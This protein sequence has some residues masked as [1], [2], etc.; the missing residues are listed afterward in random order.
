MGHL[1]IKLQLYTCVLILCT[2]RYYFSQDINEKEAFSCVCRNL[3]CECLSKIGVQIIA[4][5]N[6]IEGRG[7]W[8]FKKGRSMHGCSGDAWMLWKVAITNINRWSTI[9]ELHLVAIIILKSSSSLVEWMYEFG[10][11]FFIGFWE[12]YFQLSKTGNFW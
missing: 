7:A 2:D 10:G 11:W 9:F 5:N 4:L 1:N 6:Q 3:F 8:T 12:D